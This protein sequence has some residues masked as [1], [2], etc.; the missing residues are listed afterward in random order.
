M[1]NSSN[2]RENNQ[3]VNSRIRQKLLEAGTNNIALL[4]KVFRSAKSYDGN[5]K[6]S[7]T[8]FFRALNNFGVELRKEE[9]IVT[10]INT[11]IIEVFR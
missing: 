2:V 1:I 3:I 9:A 4:P 10:Y 5:E 11:A 6:L 8:E 7:S